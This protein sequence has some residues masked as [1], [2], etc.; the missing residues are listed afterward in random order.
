M[1]IHRISSG[2]YAAMVVP[3]DPWDKKPRLAVINYNGTDV[4][5]CFLRDYH[6]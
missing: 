4:S 3:E 6:R 1:L 5:Q 2:K